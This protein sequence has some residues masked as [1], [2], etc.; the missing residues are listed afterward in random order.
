MAK[1]QA[2]IGLPIASARKCRT[3]SKRRRRHLGP[4]AR[5]LDHQ[6][7]MAIA[8]RPYR[9]A[10]VSPSA[11]MKRVA[12]TQRLQ[13]DARFRSVSAIAYPV[14]FLQRGICWWTLR[15]PQDLAPL[16]SLSLAPGCPDVF[17]PVPQSVSMDRCQMTASGR[18]FNLMVGKLSLPIH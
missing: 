4:R 17:G 18:R 13:P 2:A 12:R 11:A 14:K 6:G 9:D 7:L 16:E 15:P 3:S 8:V 10:I 5:S 1:P